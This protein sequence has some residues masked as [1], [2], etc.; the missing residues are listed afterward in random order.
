[1]IADAKEWNG[2]QTFLAVYAAVDPIH[3]IQ[4]NTV[5]TVERSA[6][7]TSRSA[8]GHSMGL[9]GDRVGLMIGHLVPFCLPNSHQRSIKST[10]TNEPLPRVGSMMRLRTHE[11]MHPIPPSPRMGWPRSRPQGTD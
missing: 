8:H 1:M 7:G 10:P 6:D 2:R 3:G 4:T 11:G 5:Y 9:Q